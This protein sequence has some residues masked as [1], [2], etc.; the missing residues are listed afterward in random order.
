MKKPIFC[1]DVPI[2]EED[3]SLKPLVFKIVAGAFLLGVINLALAFFD[4]PHWDGPDVRSWW[5]FR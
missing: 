3:V 1:I 5:L 4:L 2:K